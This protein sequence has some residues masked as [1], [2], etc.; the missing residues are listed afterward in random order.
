[1]DTSITGH[2]VTSKEIRTAMTQG[3][4]I[5]EL[6]RQMGRQIDLGKGMFLSSD[7]LSILVEAGVFD[8]VQQ[9]AAEFLREQ[10]QERNAQKRSIRVDN[11]ASTGGPSRTF[12]SFRARHFPIT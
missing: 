5:V 10:C 2:L 1:M 12:E 6:V 4:E 7:R 3:S 9:K 8:L 11:S